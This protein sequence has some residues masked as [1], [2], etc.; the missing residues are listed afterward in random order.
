RQGRWLSLQ[1]RP[2]KNLE[3]RIDGAVLALFDVDALRRHAEELRDLCA[4]IAESI[5]EPIALLDLGLRVSMVNPAF[6]REFG[7]QAA[8]IAGQF[9]YDFAPGRW[10]AA[11]LRRLLEEEL[12]K[13]GEVRDFVLE[14]GGSTDGS[15]PLR[16]SARRIVPDS[17]RAACIVLSMRP[18]EAE[19][20][21]G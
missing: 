20:A 1:I 7:I 13:R 18:S 10:G 14:R 3:N 9:L 4:G 16:V 15:P 6:E 12:P 21:T 8:E 11:S 5:D 19:P 2:Y 17:G